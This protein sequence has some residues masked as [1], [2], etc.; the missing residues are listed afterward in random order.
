MILLISLIPNV[1]DESRVAVCRHAWEMRRREDEN[2]AVGVGALRETRFHETVYTG[3]RWLAVTNTHQAVS[4]EERSVTVASRHR[5]ADRGLLYGP[6]PCVHH[7]PRRCYCRRAYVSRDPRFNYFW[8]HDMREGDVGKCQ[9]RYD[10]W[11][12]EVHEKT[13]G[14]LYTNDNERIEW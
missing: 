8:R 7:R 2:D 12:R 6:S 14:F 5:R 9:N 4:R 13:R 1:A 10:H 3:A 11:W